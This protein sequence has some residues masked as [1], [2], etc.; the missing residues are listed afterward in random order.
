[1]T[2]DFIR[3]RSHRRAVCGAAALLQLHAVVLVVHAEEEP[4]AD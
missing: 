1:M 3:G 2:L 4:S